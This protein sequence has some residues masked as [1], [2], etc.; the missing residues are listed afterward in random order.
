M[1]T[2]RKNPR[3]SVV[4]VRVGHALLKALQTEAKK[5]G[6]PYTG[7]LKEFAAKE[8]ARLGYELEDEGMLSVGPV[9]DV[10]EPVPTSEEP[11]EDEELDMSL[12]LPSVPKKPLED[13]DL[14]AELDK[15]T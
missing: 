11:D 10:T 3:S 1:S 9:E 15:V 5:R 12:V 6:V 2:G 4:N 8:L 13:D 14:L 7:L